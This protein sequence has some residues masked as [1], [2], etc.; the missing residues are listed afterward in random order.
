[1]NNDNIIKYVGLAIKSGDVVFGVDKILNSSIVKLVVYSKE[2]KK[3]SY[4]RLVRFCDNHNIKLVICDI[5]KIYPNRNCMAI[6]ISNKN[7]C[8]IINN[9]EI[10]G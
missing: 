8:K 6:G 1:M 5:E 7:I 10:N 3:N 2:L 9:G 4:D